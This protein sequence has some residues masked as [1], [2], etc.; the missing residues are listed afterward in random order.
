MPWGRSATDVRL[1]LNL[2]FEKFVCW[3]CELKKCLLW[4][5]HRLIES[6]PAWKTV[7]M[8][9]ESAKVE[10]YGQ[11]GPRGFHDT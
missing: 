8:P 4:V 2:V 7:Q 11:L 5:R 10:A 9:K 1:T 6:D 3:R